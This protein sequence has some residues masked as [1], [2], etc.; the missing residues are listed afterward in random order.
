MLNQVVH[1]RGYIE[2]FKEFSAGVKFLLVQDNYR[3]NVIYFEEIIGKKG[4]CADVIGDVRTNNGAVE[5]G[6]S[7]VTLF[8]C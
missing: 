4:M 3:I 5:I 6:A 8:I 2:E 1:V 7:E